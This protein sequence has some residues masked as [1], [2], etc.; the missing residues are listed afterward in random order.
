MLKAY[1]SHHRSQIVSQVTINRFRC[2]DTDGDTNQ[3]TGPA[4]DLETNEKGNAF[5]VR[6]GCDRSDAMDYAAFLGRFTLEP[7]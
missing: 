3:K 1:G 5:P 7:S 2:L 4:D 6:L